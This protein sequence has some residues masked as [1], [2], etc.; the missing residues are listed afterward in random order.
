MSAC[1]QLEEA[2]AR[3]APHSPIQQPAWQAQAAAKP[4]PP[5]H[6]SVDRLPQSDAQLTS[7]CQQLA[8]AAIGHAEHRASLQQALMEL[9][10]QHSLFRDGTESADAAAGPVVNQLEQPLVPVLVLL[11]CKRQ[12]LRA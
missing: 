9:S 1:K 7:A 10:S 4:K 6:D 12:R 2:A 3:L 8:E 11:C 5:L